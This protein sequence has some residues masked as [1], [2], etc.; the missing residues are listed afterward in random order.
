MKMFTILGTNGS[1]VS[2]ACASRC[3]QQYDYDVAV[4]HP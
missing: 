4:P 1:S 3:W 2:T